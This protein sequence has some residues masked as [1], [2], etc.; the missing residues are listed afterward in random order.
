M[1]VVSAVRCAGGGLQGALAATSLRQLLRA[2]LTRFRDPKQALA[3]MS[4]AMPEQEFAAATAC[5]DV[6]DGALSMASIGGAGAMSIPRDRASLEGGDIVW[7]ATSNTIEAPSAVASLPAAGLR[8]LVEPAI[9]GIDGGCVVAVLFKGAT[10][11]RNSATFRVANDANAIPV[12]LADMADFLA[13]RDIN[14]DHVAGLDVAMDELLSNTVSY[15]FADGSAHEIVVDLSLESGDLEIELRD[16]G[17]PF[18]PLRVPPPDL[19]GD[20]EDREIGG[21]GMHFVRTVMD[22]IAYGRRDGWNVLMMRKRIADG[23]VQEEE[24]P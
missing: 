19:S 2:A 1:L 18:D 10:R 9:G 3:A 22:D 16:D 15:A 24:K 8:A 4:R 21:L 12:F 14:E 13:R 5:I 7:L 6:G 11:T 17:S 23:S 20:V